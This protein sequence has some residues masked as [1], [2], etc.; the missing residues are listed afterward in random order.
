MSGVQT[1]A[2]LAKLHGDLKLAS[3]GHSAGPS[4]QPS[5]AS[6]NSPTSWRGALHQEPAYVVAAAPLAAEEE[7]NARVLA[8]EAGGA[9][10]G[11]LLDWPDE[12]QEDGDHSVKGRLQHFNDI[13]NKAFDG[14]M[15]EEEGF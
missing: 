1:K 15:L 12:G 6:G 14:A 10:D 2:L 5:P 13:C 4:E 3:R 7:E 9:A 11:P 8:E